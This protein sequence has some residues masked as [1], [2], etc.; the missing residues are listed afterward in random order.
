MSSAVNTEFLYL[1]KNLENLSERDG[2]EA[3]NMV[4]YS[5]KE[6]L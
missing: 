6:N 2:E 3:K 5:L 1:N 4:E